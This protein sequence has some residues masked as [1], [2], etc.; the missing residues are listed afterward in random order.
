MAVDDVKRSMTTPQ[1]PPFNGNASGA[2]STDLAGGTIMQS[3]P[4]GSVPVGKDR[5][6]PGIKLGPA[7]CGSDVG[8]LAPVQGLERYGVGPVVA[9]PSTQLRVTPDTAITNLDPLAADV[10]PGY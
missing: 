7:P 10:T 4:G 6:T 2:L 3:A 5:D 8:L 9:A 1:A